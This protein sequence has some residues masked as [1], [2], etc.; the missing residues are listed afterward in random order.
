MSCPL[1]VN[2]VL[3]PCP[4]G[5]FPPVSLLPSRP[6]FPD[7]L[8]MLDGRQVTSK[9]QWVNERRPELKALFQ[10]YMYGEL[11]PVPKELSAK[12]ER[13]DRHA[14]DGQATLK[15]VTL[16]FR[17]PE[18]PP[19]HLLV[20]VPN[21]R[22][23]PAPAIL[24]LNPFGNH[25]LVKDPAVRLPDIW[26]PESSP[27]VKDNR[28][29][30]A[31]RGKW[32][33]DS[34]AIEPTLDRG[35]AVATFYKGDVDFDSP[36]HR[37]IQRYLRKQADDSGSHDCGTI[38]AWAW[39]LQRAVDYLV[40]DKEIDPSRI[41][42]TGWSR[43]GKAALLAAAFDERI[44]LAIPHQ[45]G[46]GGSAPSRTA[47]KGAEKVKDGNGQFPYWYNSTFKEFND[48]PD[49]LP[50]DQHCLV[51]LCAPRPVL[52]SNAAQNIWIN[53]AG[54]FDV[55]QAADP[56][57]RF[58]G[59]GGLEAKR[60]PPPG[61]LIDSRLGY[62]LRPGKHSVTEEDWS[63]FLAFADKH[64]GKPA[65]PPAKAEPNKNL[66]VRPLAAAA[67]SPLRVHPTNPRYFTDGSGKAVYLTGSHT[68]WN[69][70]DTGPSDPPPVF[71]YDAYLDFLKK[72]HH[73]F[74]RLWRWELTTWPWNDPRELKGGTAVRSY[75]APHPWKRTGP[76]TALDGKPKFD[77]DQ[78]DPAYFDRLRARVVAADRQGI[79]VS[80]MLFEGFALFCR[81]AS[82]WAG[83]PMNVLN[84][85]QGING[86]QDGD[87]LGRELH[88]LAMPAVTRIQEAYVRKVIDTVNDL[89]NV[90]YEVANESNFDFSKEWQY[91][92]IRYVKEYERGK[93]QQ[94]PIGMTGYTKSDNGVMTDSPADW[95]SP[96]STG[97]TR[98]PSPFKTDP[99]ATDGKKVVILDT[100][101]IWGEGGGR[102]WVWK[103]FLRGYNPIWMDYYPDQSPWL[104]RTMDAEDT[105]RNLGYAL[106]Y[107]ERMNLAATTP[108]NELA[109]SGYCLAN[110][111]K[112][113][114]VYLPDGGAVTVDLGAVKG[115]LTVEWMHPVKG[116]ITSGEATAGGAKRQFKAPFAGDAVLY[117]ATKKQEP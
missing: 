89:D 68:W 72:H 54:Q 84:N 15:E 39:G 48:Q 13:E 69:L 23:R 62:F 117:I 28:A 6:D 57:Y 70:Q 8:V 71:D 53:P 21:D 10:H 114:L 67:T 91:H 63:A 106:R 110:P 42:V 5:D 22:T 112:E 88:T 76:G 4:A 31:G 81:P 73:N 109:S 18:L 25:T 80:I 96:G 87:G 46:L 11:P 75:A 24:S 116:T 61:T 9:E 38:A 78:F 60:M 105:R 43:R 55:L 82:H 40:T 103:S 49:R 32:M 99:P 19:I 20:I 113:Y 104:P 65:V 26:V 107:A 97:D 29:T 90:L 12:L 108:R 30:E 7:P 85:V 59:V 45:A 101:H 111:R 52:F 94:H 74:F 36:D 58:L 37:G 100:D 77:F 79:Y 93:P 41:V 35:Y 16:S 83:H 102:D 44:S 51:A 95:I 14:F 92:M 66:R 2:H 47:I 115:P 1:C 86:D 98:D 64:L 33:I 34:W 50:F 56:V 3:S 17:F 27:G